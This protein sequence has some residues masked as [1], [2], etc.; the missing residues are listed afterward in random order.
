MDETEDAMTTTEQKET[1]QLIHQSLRRA[2]DQ[3]AWLTDEQIRSACWDNLHDA[4]TLATVGEARR[5]LVE[6]GL[7][8]VRK[9]AQ[10][11]FA[12]RVRLSGGYARGAV[13]AGTPFKFYRLSKKGREASVD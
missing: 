5:R 4:P 10:E 2:M 8:E 13:I 11:Q 6:D 9:E 7:L 3:D 12:T 1:K